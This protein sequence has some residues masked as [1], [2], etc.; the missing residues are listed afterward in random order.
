M[1]VVEDKIVE[2]YA[3]VQASEEF[4]AEVRK[5]IQ[6]TLEDEDALG[7]GGRCVV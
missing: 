4:T 5:L 7:S 2:H 6:E 1:E 3:L